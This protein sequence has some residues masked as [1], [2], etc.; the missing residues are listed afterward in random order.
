MAK[1]SSSTS[2]SSNALS[3]ALTTGASKPWFDYHRTWEQYFSN[4]R[5]WVEWGTAWDK[6]L[7]DSVRNMGDHEIR[8][9][10]DS[11]ARYCSGALIVAPTVYSSLWLFGDAMRDAYLLADELLVTLAMLASAPEP[12]VSE[13]GEKSDSGATTMPRMRTWRGVLMSPVYAGTALLRPF[14][15]P[16]RQLVR[17]VSLTPRTSSDVRGH[18][19]VASTVCLLLLEAPLRVLVLRRY[20]NQS[21]DHSAVGTLGRECLP[22]AC[23]MLGM[24]LNFRGG[25]EAREKGR[26]SDETL[27]R[28]SMTQAGGGLLQGDVL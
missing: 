23:C 15:H 16:Y 27:L 26:R 10:K 28:R 4:P 7:F 1:K 9:L 13:G 11:L 21:D 20:L 6:F 22:A 3:N 24:W 25:M 8:R 5:T 2:T 12:P 18:L 19:A 17:R 14:V